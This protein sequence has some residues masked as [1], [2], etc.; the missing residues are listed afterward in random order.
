MGK[1]GWDSIGG[2]EVKWDV[3]WSE[4]WTDAE[5]DAWWTPRQEWTDE[6]WEEWWAQQQNWDGSWEDKA[7]SWADKKWSDWSDW[8]E[9]PAVPPATAEMTVVV[10]EGVAAGD[11]VQ[12]T[13]P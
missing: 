11:A 1:P 3:H 6:E 13:T 2:S 8:T 7:G 10:P 4:Q 9:P 5:W 12:V